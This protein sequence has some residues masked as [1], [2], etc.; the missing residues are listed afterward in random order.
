M[1]GNPEVESK[2]FETVE[3]LGHWNLSGGEGVFQDGL[4]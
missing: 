4:L 2:P 3:K 1:V